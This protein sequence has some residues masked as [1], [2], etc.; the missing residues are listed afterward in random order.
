MSNPVNISLTA[1]TWTAVALNTTLAR[2]VIKQS[3][4]HHYLYTY[5]LAGGSAPSDDTGAQAVPAGRRV[6]CFSHSEPID[7]YA[8]SVGAAGEVMV[9]V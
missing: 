2:A 4:A 3:G 9:M 8:K 7:C 6:I 5:R 1:D